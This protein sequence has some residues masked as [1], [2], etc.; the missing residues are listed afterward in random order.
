VCTLSGTSMQE[1]AVSERSPNP[2]DR[3]VVPR[4]PESRHTCCGISPS[5]QGQ[6]NHAS[7]QGS[8]ATLLQDLL[9]T[10]CSP[11]TPEQK[12]DRILDRRCDFLEVNRDG[13]PPLGRQAKYA[14]YAVRLVVRADSP[15]L[16]CGCELTVPVGKHLTQ[17]P[18]HEGFTPATLDIADN[19]Q[20]RIVTGA[21]I[22]LLQSPL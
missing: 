9:R 10:T 13:S 18:S 8:R 16:C 17:E 11:A 4:R 2:I 7:G 5:R 3:K 21:A 20:T 19:Q 15:L 1:T 6:A 22:A 12:P 14:C